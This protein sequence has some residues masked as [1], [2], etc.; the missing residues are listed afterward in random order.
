M[1]TDTA[2]LRGREPPVYS[3]EEGAAFPTGFFQIQE[4]VSPA[5]IGDRLSKPEGPADSCHVQVLYP[6]DVISPCQPYC[7]LV[8]EI[9]TL[10]LGF[11]MQLCDLPAL[12]PVI[13]RVLFHL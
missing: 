8:Q 3:Y 11:R 13:G 9:T 12:S 4:E 5:I 6:N 1:P 2:G 7:G 10:M